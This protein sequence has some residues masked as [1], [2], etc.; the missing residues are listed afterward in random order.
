MASLVTLAQMREHIETDLSDAE[1][2]RMI[3]SAEQDI[4]DH[5]GAHLTQTDE[6]QENKLS[7]HLFLSRPAST[8]TTVTETMISD[9]VRTETVL[10]SGDE[11]E[12]PDYH[13]T[14]DGWRIQRLSDGTNPRSTWGDEVEVSYVPASEAAKRQ[15]V[16]IQLVKLDVQFN[17]LDVDRVGDYSREQKDYMGHRNAIMRRLSKLPLA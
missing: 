17:G 2:Q 11:S 1:L 5:Y 10:D 14:S 12:T 9:G 15:G 7:T 13:L 16:L 8:I 4:V 6:S 3:D